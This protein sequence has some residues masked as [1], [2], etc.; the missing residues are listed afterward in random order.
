MYH[1]LEGRSNGWKRVTKEGR[2]QVRIFRIDIFN[3]TNKL[4]FLHKK[5][6]MI[7]GQV[8]YQY[9]GNFT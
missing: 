7:F 5:S 2:D 8:Q 1:D 3:K 9:S 6:I 4:T